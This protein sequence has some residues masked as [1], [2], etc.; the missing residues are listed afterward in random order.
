MNLLKAIILDTEDGEIEVSTPTVKAKSFVGALRKFK[1]EE[2][3]GI[4]K[5]EDDTYMVFIE[6]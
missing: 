1:G 2:V 5:I 6:E 4:L 3:L